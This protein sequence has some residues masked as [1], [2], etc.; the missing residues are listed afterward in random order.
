VYD[1]KG[2]GVITKDEI[3]ELL[4]LM[5]GNNLTEEQINLIACKT[6]TEYDLDGDGK[7]NE[8]EFSKVRIKYRYQTNKPNINYH[9]RE[10]NNWDIHTQ[11]EKR[12]KRCSSSNL[13]Y[14]TH[15]TTKFN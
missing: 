11:R 5:V 2:D 14:T 6:L 8:E 1:T 10:P 15:N 12:E 7:I 13:F 4:K 3:V 9:C